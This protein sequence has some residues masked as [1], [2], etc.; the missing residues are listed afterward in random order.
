MA[1]N[2]FAKNAKLFA[3]SEQLYIS[4]K[5]ENVFLSDGHIIVRISVAAYDLYFRP[6]SGVFLSMEDGE[7]AE[8]RNNQALPEKLAFAF[9]VSKAFDE[10]KT[11]TYEYV[12]A[13][14]F[15]MEYIDNKKKILHRML[16]GS[17]FYVSI[18]N[19]YYELCE[20]LNINTFKSEGKS[21]APVIAETDFCNYGIAI[22]PVRM[23]EQKIMDFVNV[24]R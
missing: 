20:E 1:K 9:D 15:L 13:S 5:N 14:A 12:N 18:N 24:S 19:L 6:V 22:L 23:N 10:M 2:P 11:K 17:G 8:K 21:T 4:R 7:K 16:T 3:K